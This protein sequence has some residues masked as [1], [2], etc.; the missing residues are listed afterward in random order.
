M[1]DKLLNAAL[2]IA[3]SI[4]CYVAFWNVQIAREFGIVG[5]EWILLF[6]PVAIGIL[7]LRK[8]KG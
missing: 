5:G 3:I 7:I 1:I 8:K 6:V 2:L 4:L